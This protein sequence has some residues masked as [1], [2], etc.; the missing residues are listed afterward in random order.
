MQL[1][2]AGKSVEAISR[3]LKAPRSS[4]SAS[5]TRIRFKMFEIV[6]ALEFLQT[7][8]FI[9]IEKGELRFLSTTMDPKALRG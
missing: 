3:E 4:I 9:K 1:L 7:V 5:I 8:G 2:K 6:S